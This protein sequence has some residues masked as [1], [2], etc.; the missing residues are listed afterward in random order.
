MHGEE[1]GFELWAEYLLDSMDRIRKRLGGARHQELRK[2]MAD[3]IDEQRRTGDT[4]GHD[5]WIR[6]LLVDYYDPMYDYQIGNK[7]DRIVAR[8]D[9]DL[10]RDWIASYKPI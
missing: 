6:S 1:Q 3:A 8:G 10:L 9:A 7:V 4:A 5:A 2:I